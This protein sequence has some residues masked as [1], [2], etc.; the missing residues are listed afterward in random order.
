ML[1]WNKQKT[2]KVNTLKGIGWG[3]SAPPFCWHPRTVPG[4]GGQAAITHHPDLKGRFLHIALH[5]PSLA[6][7]AYLVSDYTQAALV[8][9]CKTANQ[10][11]YLDLFRPVVS[12]LTLFLSMFSK[13]ENLKP[14]RNS[15]QWSDIAFFALVA[16]KCFTFSKWLKVI[17]VKKSLIWCFHYA[18]KL[19]E[20]TFLPAAPKHR[21]KH[22]YPGNTNMLKCTCQQDLFGQLKNFFL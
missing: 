11:S 1:K 20:G 8:A 3:A 17:T 6:S 18:N 14:K 13:Q 15:Q 12:R 7:W 19:I 21:Q 22:T 2:H 4:V 5:L 10:I 9:P 16:K